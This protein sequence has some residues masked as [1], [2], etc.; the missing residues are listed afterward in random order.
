MFVEFAA[1][2]QLRK[3]DLHSRYARLR[4]DI[5]R[6][7]AP[8]V[9]DGCAAVLVQF[10]LDARGIAVGSLVNGIVDDL[11]KDMMQPLDARRTDVHARP[12][13]DRV[14]PFEYADIFRTVFLFGHR[15]LLA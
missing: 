14:Q 1:R 10:D 4:V 15:F 3:D 12:Q 13:A 2:V 8:V 7:T 9:L 5:R 11:P 6:D